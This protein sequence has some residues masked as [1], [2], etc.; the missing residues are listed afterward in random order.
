MLFD[1]FKSVLD[2]TG[3]LLM[4]VL[5]EIDVIIKNRGDVL[6]YEL[7]HINEALQNKNIRFDIRA[8]AFDRN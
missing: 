8:P 2:S 7:T 1:R 5:D 4:V 6:L 3:M